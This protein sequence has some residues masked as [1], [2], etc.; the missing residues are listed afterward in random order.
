[1]P[2]NAPS[3]P[4]EPLLERYEIV[5]VPSVSVIAALRS[6]DRTTT[7]PLRA[8]IFADP[9]FQRSDP[10]LMTRESEGPGN[11]AADLHQDAASLFERLPATASEATTIAALLADTQPLVATGFAA[12]RIA[13]L[14]DDLSPYRLL[15]FATHGVMDA[16]YPELSSLVLSQFDAEG[17]Q[18]EGALRIHELAR[19]DIDADLVVLSACDTALGREIRGEGL[20][21]FVQSFL[22]AGSQR[23]LVS[24][25]KVPD[26][27]TAELMTNFYSH[28]VTDA[29]SPA[30]ALRRAQLAIA[31]KPRWRAPLYWAGFVLIGEWT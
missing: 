13:L 18:I 29:L 31:S 2:A 19:I 9:V 21:G 24:L 6:R 1:L 15:H 17:H 20:V 30:A 10:R 14:A 7:R 26:A 8:A 25:W 3:G 4:V 23:L 11:A 27:A 28:M 5:H 16:R 22:T 12:N